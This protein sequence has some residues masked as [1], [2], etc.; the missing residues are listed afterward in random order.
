MGRRLGWSDIAPLSVQPAAKINRTNTRGGN[1][2]QARCEVVSGVHRGGPVPCRLTI[3]SVRPLACQ[4][5]LWP[6]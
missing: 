3:V 6:T 4:P 5:S 1:R 2:E